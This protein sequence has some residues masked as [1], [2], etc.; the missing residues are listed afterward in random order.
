MKFS[1]IEALVAQIQ[2][3]ILSAREVLNAKR[4]A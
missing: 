2:R 1:G 4:E 3:D